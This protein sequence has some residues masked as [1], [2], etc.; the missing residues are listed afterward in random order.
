M[1]THMRLIIFFAAL[2]FYMNCQANLPEK[3]AI[4]AS[5]HG[6]DGRAKQQD[7]PHLAGQSA[8]YL[9]KQLRDYQ[10]KTRASAIMQAFVIGLSEKEMLELSKY[11]SN[12]PQNSSPKSDKTSK[13]G[14]ILYKIGNREKKITACIACHGPKGNGNDAA[15]YPNIRH[16]QADYLKNQLQA[17][18]HQIRKNDPKG[19]MRTLSKQ[20]SDQDMVDLV[21]YLQQLP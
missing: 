3:L 15:K 8:N 18:H 6:L 21:T 7:Y 5:C 14:E 20:L 2:V 9:L 10:T 1:L 4:C 11:Y 12:L 17:F 13:S 19:I 16:Q